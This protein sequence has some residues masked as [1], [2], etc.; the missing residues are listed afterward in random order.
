MPTK[1]KFSGGEGEN[2][3][4]LAR[5]D[6]RRRYRHTETGASEQPWKRRRLT[7]GVG[8]LENRNLD[9]RRRRRRIVVI[10]VV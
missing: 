8:A 6:S 7:R 1:S 9:R 3:V 10:V 4:R 2:F 5:N